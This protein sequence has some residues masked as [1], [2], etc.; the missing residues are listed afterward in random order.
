MSRA[1][2]VQLIGL[3]SVGPVSLPGDRIHGD[4]RLLVDHPEIVHLYIRKNRVR[5]PAKK[6][7]PLWRPFVGKA[8]PDPTQ[9]SPTIFN[10]SVYHS[11]QD[12]FL[13]CVLWF[14]GGA[15]GALEYSFYPRGAKAFPTVQLAEA[16][17]VGLCAPVSSDRSLALHF[18][19]EEPSHQGYRAL[20]EGMRQAGLERCLLLVGQ[21]RPGPN[22]ESPSPQLRAVLCQ[23]SGLC[24]PGP[25]F[26]PSALEHGWLACYGSTG[27]HL[28]FANVGEGLPPAL[29]PQLSTLGLRLWRRSDVAHAIV[30]KATGLMAGEWDRMI[31]QFLEKQG[32]A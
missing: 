2:D 1:P 16:E 5:H 20:G 6:G 9:A 24:D 15:T 18:L 22:T 12:A 23:A 11:L 21:I 10:G 7:A 25:T 4:R 8:L 31:M 32:T 3:P 14:G 19:P 17:A 28:R 26:P 30:G 13:A 27:M 29:L